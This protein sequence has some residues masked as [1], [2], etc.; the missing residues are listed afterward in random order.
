M[1]CSKQKSSPVFYR[2]SPDFFKVL[3]HHFC[4]TQCPNVLWIWVVLYVM[5]AKPERTWRLKKKKKTKLNET[6]VCLTC[7]LMGIMKVRGIF[8]ATLAEK[9]M[10]VSELMTL[11]SLWW[12]TA[13]LLLCDFC[14]ES[15]R[16]VY[17]S[18]WFATINAL[19]LIGVIVPTCSGSVI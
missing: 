3:L 13:I 15:E 6:Q 7:S 14:M 12:E 16:F 2:P 8:G 1:E 19:S 18:V 9:K 4:F 11:A 10:T 17:S 5:S